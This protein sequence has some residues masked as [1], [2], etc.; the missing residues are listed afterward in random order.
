[1]SF[2]TFICMNHLFGKLHTTSD[3]NV[4]SAATI[5]QVTLDTTQDPCGLKCWPEDAHFAR[6]EEVEILELFH[7]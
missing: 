3:A 1:M 2:G 5:L 6:E 4:T 7:A